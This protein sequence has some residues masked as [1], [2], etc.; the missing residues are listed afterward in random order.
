MRN[1]QERAILQDQVR[2]LISEQEMIKQQAEY[3]RQKA[4]KLEE[5]L[6]EV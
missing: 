2:E 5:I 4:R 6:T 1:E 3:E